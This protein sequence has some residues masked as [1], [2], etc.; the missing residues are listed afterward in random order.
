M[1][2]PAF[3]LNPKSIGAAEVSRWARTMLKTAFPETKFRVRK[4]GIGDNVHDSVMI[5]WTDGPAEDDVR[6]L[7]PTVKGS[8]WDGSIDLAS[9][10]YYWLT[11]DW[12]TSIAWREG[13]KSYGGRYPSE[14]GD[15]PGDDAECVHFSMQG[16]ILERSAQNP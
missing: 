1:A 13:T 12:K 16:F 14:V 15:K 7:L 5:Q 8:E 4:V 9:N 10:I 3:A 2:L 6:A 11:P